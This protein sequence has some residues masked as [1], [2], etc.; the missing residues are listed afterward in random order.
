[1][2]TLHT[3]DVD[4]LRRSEI[5]PTL[6][7]NPSITLAAAVE[8]AC[9]VAAGGTGRAALAQVTAQWFG[10]LP[11]WRTMTAWLVDGDRPPRVVDP[12][13]APVWE[14]WAIERDDDVTGTD[15]R[16]YQDRFRRSATQHGFTTSLGAAL[17]KALAEM[18]DNVYQHSGGVRGFVVFCFAER[19]VA[20]CVADLGRGVLGSLRSSE[21]WA[22]LSNARDALG[23]AWFQHATR[24]PGPNSG[25]G[26]REVERSLAA[27][28]GHL[29]FRTDDA[30]LELDGRSGGLQPKTA[31]NPMLRGLQLSATCAVGGTSDVLVTL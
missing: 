19:C 12:A 28:N 17:S 11:L 20:W 23:A 16:L 1:V 10:R 6:A 31:S 5:V 7:G 24:R 3:I 27:L 21:R 13:S 2:T 30:V 9:T 4:G 8:L 29:R 25:T 26:F 15:W 22:H 14:M 18:A